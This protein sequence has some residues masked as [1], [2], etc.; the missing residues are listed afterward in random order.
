MRSVLA[1]FAG[2]FA[3]VQSASALNMY[4]QCGVC[5]LLNSFTLSERY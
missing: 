2:L 1:S 4:D 3:L 5:D